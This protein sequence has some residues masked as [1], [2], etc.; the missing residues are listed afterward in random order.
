MVGDSGSKPPLE[1]IEPVLEGIV[2]KLSAAGCAC[3]FLHAY[4]GDRTSDDLQPILDKYERVADHYGIP[5]IHLGLAI[6]DG[7]ASGAWSIDELFL[8]RLHTTPK[9]AQVVA[10]LA[11]QAVQHI[12]AVEPAPETVLHPR[13]HAD[14][15][16]GSRLFLPDANMT[17]LPDAFR[18]SRFRL[19]LSLIELESGNGLWIETAPGDIWGLLIVAGPKTGNILIETNGARQEYRTWDKWCDRDLLRTVTFAVPVRRGAE[20]RLLVTDRGGPE[21][22]GLETSHPKNLKLVGLMLVDDSRP[23][24]PTDQKRGGV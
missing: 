22:G 15:L 3:C 19:V 17:L 5:S 2:L 21:L 18:T 24:A 8:D 10:N 4:R 9:G 16:E 14:Y 13:L 23:A 20:L 6:S 7:E 11:A 12:L 1:S